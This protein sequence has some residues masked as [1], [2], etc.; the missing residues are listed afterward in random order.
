MPET[1]PDLAPA[2]KPHWTADPRESSQYQA[3]RKQFRDACRLHRNQDGTYGAPCSR[4]HRPINCALQYPHPLAF[5]LD[6]AEP[7]RSRP[8]LALA[9]ANFQPAHWSCNMRKGGYL[10]NDADLDV[11]VPSEDW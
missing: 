4:C 7:V 6:H 10:D 8:D 3:L 2:P 5:S 11:G 9:P 1:D